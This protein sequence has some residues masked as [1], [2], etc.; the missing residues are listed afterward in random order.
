MK[1]LHVHSGN[2]FGGVETTLLAQA[3]HKDPELDM[4]MSFALCFAGRF[5]EE[6]AET[7]A[8]VHW[9]NEVRVRRPLSVRRARQKLRSLLHVKQFDV[10]V[11]HSCWSQAVFSCVVK[12][13]GLPLVFW[14]HGA[15]NGRHWLELWAKRIAPNFV[16]SNSYFSA[17][18]LRRLYRDIPSEVIY[19]PFVS[20]ISK[21]NQKTNLA[22][23]TSADT[24]PDK[25][26]IV[27][28]SR[29]EAGKGHA[30]HLEALSHLRDLPWV[31]WQV[32]GAQ[33]PSEARYL[34][35]LKETAEKFGIANR[36][37]FLGDC[38]D[39]AA[40]LSSADL[41]CQPNVGP[42]GFGLTLIEALQASLPV[43]S[44]D[45]GG[46]REIVDD[47]CGVLIPSGSSAVLAEALRR[48]IV[49]RP[50]R[51]QLSLGGPERARHLCDVPTQMRRLQD[52]LEDV[53]HSSRT[54]NKKW[55]S[56]SA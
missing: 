5:S 35:G 47:S 4:E 6:L 56:F 19:Y 17:D 20:N 22:V 53:C 44:T 43:I 10:V 23:R 14:Q 30:L 42:E 15:A 52:L 7:S 13:E 36:V 29:M 46:P 38:S 18:T 33:R 34:R 55:L 32:G 37:R 25:I 49:D 48:L 27:Q 26:V 54:P 12:R 8:Q 28:V 51:E 31:C 11:T 2:L 40:I 1:V 24:A 3:R 9:L 41:Y 21:P 16:L 45:S 50:L 39:V